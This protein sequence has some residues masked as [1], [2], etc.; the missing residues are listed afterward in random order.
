MKNE[1][2]AVMTSMKVNYPTNFFMY[3][4]RFDFTV[5]KGTKT[6]ISCY[7]VSMQITF[8]IITYEF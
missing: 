8:A 6:I 2:C 3:V 4:R 1:N 7:L 5:S